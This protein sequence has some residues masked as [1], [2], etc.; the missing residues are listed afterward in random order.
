MRWVTY[1]SDTGV[2]G[3]DRCHPVPPGVGLIE[4][5]GRGAEELRAAGRRD[6]GQ[7]AL[8]AMMAE[9]ALS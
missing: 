6:P 4:L 5:V 9:G 8:M 1:A 3:G 2:M 7:L